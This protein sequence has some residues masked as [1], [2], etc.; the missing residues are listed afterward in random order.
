MKKPAQKATA[1]PPKA[2]E[3]DLFSMGDD[4]DFASPAAPSSTNPA[5]SE[6][7]S[8]SLDGKFS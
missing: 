8:V 5:A 4:D 1:P 6:N 2:K 7:A 3:V